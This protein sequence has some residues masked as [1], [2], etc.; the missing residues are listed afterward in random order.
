MPPRPRRRPAPRCRC[1]EFRTRAYESDDRQL[2]L[3]AVLDTLQDEGFVV[4]SADS[5][6][7]LITATR[8]TD[9]SQ[10]AERLLSLLDDDITWKKLAVLEATANVT[11]FGSQTRVRL[12]IQRRL[13][14]NRGATMRLERVPPGLYRQLLAAVDEAV[15]LAKEKLQSAREPTSGGSPIAVR[16]R[17]SAGAAHGSPALPEYSFSHCCVASTAGRRPRWWTRRRREGRAG[18]CPRAAPE[19]RP[20]CRASGWS[21]SPP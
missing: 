21:R 13:V 12:S 20:G 5:G 1:G 15:F 9:V 14:D 11:P 4:E 8:E 2:V 7:G 16:C 10:K 3:K 6:L 17:Q 19:A 18:R